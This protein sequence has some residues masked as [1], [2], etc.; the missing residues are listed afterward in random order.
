[1]LIF[2]CLAA[3]GVG[4]GVARWQSDAPPATE[5]ADDAPT[6]EMPERIDYALTE[7]SLPDDKAKRMTTGTAVSEELVL[8]GTSEG[9]VYSVDLA[10]G[11]AARP[12]LII[13]VPGSVRN[14]QISADGGTAAVLSEEGTL[15]VMDLSR[16]TSTD[17][18]MDVLEGPGALSPDGSLFVYGSFDPTVLDVAT[19]K[20]RTLPG[21]PPPEG[22]RA[23]YED[24]AVTED[25]M[26]RAANSGSAGNP[27]GGVETWDPAD[28]DLIGETV[29]CGCAA[30]SVTLNDDGS[31]ATF[32]T[33]NGHAVVVDLTAGSVLGDKTISNDNIWSA[34]IFG[35]ERRAAAGTPSGRVVIWDVRERRTLW[36]H[37]FPE[38]QGQVEQVSATPNSEALLIRINEQSQS[39]QLWL[40]RPAS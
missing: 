5:T 33:A 39:Q 21:K 31:I 16:G 29:N 36:Q 26:I 14:I 38:R 37:T 28:P 13:T 8:V 1:M 6:E 34:T 19:G 11:D 12:E 20:T 22:G 27:D 3:V 30:S 35:D 24:W 25:G 40:A 18:V 9:H 7:V 4:V 10:S 32:G 2:A 15:R 17:I 23:A